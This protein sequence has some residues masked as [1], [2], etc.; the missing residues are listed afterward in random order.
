MN[1]VLLLSSNWYEVAQLAVLR[2]QQFHDLQDIEDRILPVD[3]LMSEIVDDRAEY[4]DKEHG[5]ARE[6]H[7][8]IVVRL[9][10]QVTGAFRIDENVLVKTRAY[11]PGHWK[12]LSAYVFTILD[13]L[14]EA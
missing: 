3:W 9:I 5:P 6:L 12:R 2:N 10:A 8:F 11:K 14:R 13:S 1:V 7:D 4:A